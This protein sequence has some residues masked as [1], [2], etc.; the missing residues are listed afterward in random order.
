[1]TCESQ[2][3]STPGAPARPAA[4]LW[5]AHTHL[6]DPALAPRLDEILERADRAGVEVMVVAGTHPDDWDCIAKLV[7]RAPHRLRA[8]Y[9]VHPL[10]LERLP[11]DWED[12]LAS[13]L[14]ADPTATIGEIGLDHTVQPRDDEQQEHVFLR[15]LALARSLGRAVTV[16]VR[17]A[18]GRAL[19]LL[20]Q[21]GPFEIPVVLH[22]Y[23]GGAELVPALEKIGAWFSFSTTLTWPHNRRGPEAARV[24]PAERLLVETDSP[25]LSPKSADG[26]APGLNEPANLVR[27]VQRL[28]EIRAGTYDEWAQ[29]TFDNA[30]RCFGEFRAQLH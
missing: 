2:C 10:Y 12:R 26:S 11:A 4:R 23:G 17:R 24:A 5:D 19:E 8:A 7:A 13:R 29:R 3:V 14:A 22:S 6:Q 27:V 9:G 21:E 1:M 20:R 16:H 25:D 30:A 15:Q 18:W 28:A